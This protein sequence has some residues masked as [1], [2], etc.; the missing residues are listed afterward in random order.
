MIKRCFIAAILAVLFM[1]PVNSFTVHAYSDDSENDE[2]VETIT[3]LPVL[4]TPDLEEEPPRPF[5]P[6]GTGTVVDYA[7]DSDSK[8]FYTIIT[9][10][11]NVFYLIIDNQRNQ[12]NVYFLNA[13]TEADLM[14]LAVM[15]ERPTSTI[16]YE[17]PTEITEQET[18][19]IEQIPDQE[20]ND[21]TGVI[22]LILVVAVIGGGAGWYFKVYKPKQMK[23]VD[24]DEYEPHLNEP[25]N[26][27]I[28]DWDDIQ[29][30]TT[31][32]PPWDEDENTNE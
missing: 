24:E 2:Q 9:P 32:N 17:P 1:L 28:N 5:T 20:D 7:T 22:I 14:A 23:T 13:V 19:P 11:E 30:D 15:P 16:V 8:E 26:D 3:E 27:Y 29:I 10:N 18:D 31:D 4:Q 25:D 21:N 12:Q 6:P